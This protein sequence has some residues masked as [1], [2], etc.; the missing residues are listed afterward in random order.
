M[1]EHFLAFV[2][3]LQRDNQ[4]ARKTGES[5]QLDLFLE[6][7]IEIR[8]EVL[9]GDIALG[10]VTA[11]TKAGGNLSTVAIQ[12][13]VNRWRERTAALLNHEFSRRHTKI[14]E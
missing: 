9:A 5:Q 10:F 4:V 6:D 12:L 1:T 11:V 13:A 14:P 3:R 2:S 7:E 8:S